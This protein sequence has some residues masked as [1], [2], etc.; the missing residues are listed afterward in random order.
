[1][2]LPSHGSNPH[3]IYESLKLAQPDR[4]IDFSANVNPLGPPPAL[5][6]N[7]MEAFELITTYPD[8]NASSLTS[9]LASLNH[10]QENELLIGNGGAELITLVGRYLAGKRICIVQPAFS[11]YEEACRSA[12]CDITYHT[13]EEGRWTLEPTHL[14]EKMPYVD[15]IFLCTPNNP[16][17][18]TYDPASVLALFEASEKH[19]CLLIIDEA[20]A[21]FLSEDTSYVSALHTFSKLVLLR[22]LTKMYAI[23]GL[24]LGY[25]MAH[26]DIISAVD[27][28]QPHWSVNALALMAGELCLQ[29]KEH[30]NETRDFI[31]QERETLQLF[32]EKNHYRYSDSSVNFYLLKDPELEDQAPLMHYLMENGIVPRHTENFPG[33]N[34]KWLRFAIRTSDENRRLME[35]LEAWRR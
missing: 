4:S 30:V 29:E 11:E 12:G 10:V 13:L 25:M 22:S 32:F 16:T 20:F 3:Y 18:V 26:P 2:T 15:A 5:K 1:M 23:P 21:D 8:P 33:L 28:L 6:D 17:G 7:W 35:V 34:G 9:K 31:Q 14:I 19:N 24:R 27:A